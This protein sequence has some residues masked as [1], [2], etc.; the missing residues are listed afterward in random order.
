[1]DLKQEQILILKELIRKGGTGNVNEIL[2]LNPSQFEEGFTI[3]NDMQNKDL[4]KLLY[5]NFNKNLVVAELTLLGE[6]EYNKLQ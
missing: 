1:M 3:A 4:L 2:S 6:S 5:S